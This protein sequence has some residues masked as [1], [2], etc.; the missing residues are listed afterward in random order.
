MSIIQHADRSR[1]LC[2]P[3][4]ILSCSILLLC[5]SI[6]CAGVTCILYSMFLH[7]KTPQGV[8]SVHRASQSIGASSS[9]KLYGFFPFKYDTIQFQKYAGSL[10]R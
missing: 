4:E 8:K 10:S 7:K 2:S 1:V 6:E 5:P 3:H 9:M